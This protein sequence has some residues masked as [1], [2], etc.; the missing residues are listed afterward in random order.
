MQSINYFKDDHSK[1]DYSTILEL[2][3]GALKEAHLLDR[4]VIEERIEGFMV[5][6]KIIDKEEKIKKFESLAGSA[7]PAGEDVKELIDMAN[8]KEEWRGKE[9]E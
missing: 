6:P 1:N 8:R 7:I 3:K 2:V 4:I 5:K 9:V